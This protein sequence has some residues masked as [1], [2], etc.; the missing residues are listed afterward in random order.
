MSSESVKTER[1]LIK[2]L[3]KETTLGPE[4]FNILRN[5]V[6]IWYMANIASGKQVVS[7]ENAR[8]AVNSEGELVLTNVTGPVK[9][10]ETKTPRGTIEFSPFPPPSE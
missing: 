6:F 1:E 2:E 9:I 7:V 5:Q 4:K 8:I 3:R 10:H